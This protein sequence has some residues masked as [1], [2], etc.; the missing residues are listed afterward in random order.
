MKYGYFRNIALLSLFLNSALEAGTNRYWTGASDNLW[1]NNANWDTS[2]PH[3]LD[4]A[5]L[6]NGSASNKNIASDQNIQI[7]SLLISAAGYSLNSAQHDL[8]FSS[9]LN[10]NQNF[11][12]TTDTGSINLGDLQVAQNTL[13]IN[14]TGSG[15]ITFNNATLTGSGIINVTSSSTGNLNV[16]GL[17]TDTSSG[18]LTLTSSGRGNINLSNNAS[19]GATNVILSNNYN[20]LF[21]NQAI[22]NISTG[23]I[24][25]NGSI[26]ING[27]NTTLKGVNTYKGATILNSAVLYLDTAGSISSSKETILNGSSRLDISSATTP[28]TINHLSGDSDAVIN[29]GS[30]NLTVNLNLSYSFAVARYNSDG[31]LD[32]TFGDDGKV[33][34][35]IDN[36]SLGTGVAQQSSGKII[37]GGYSTNN[38]RTD[39]TMVRYNTD[40]SLDSSF[41]EEGIITTPI[42]SNSAYARAVAVD[43]DDHIALAG[44]NYTGSRYN[45][46]VAKYDPNGDLDITF[47][48]SGIVSTEIG[49]SDD[50]ARAVVINN[51]KI[52]AAGYTYLGSGSNYDFALVRYNSDGTLDTNFNGTG[53]VTTSFGVGND[54]A[55]GIA[56]QE[57]DKIVTSGLATI[58]GSQ[59]FALARYNNDGTLD[60][61]FNNTGTVTTSF[62]V[63]S[64]QSNGV[65]IQGDDKIVA[66]G[67]ATIT[68]NNVTTADFALAKY[69]SDGTL[70]TNFNGT[71]KVTTN[72]PFYNND[73]S[74][75]V[76]IQ[77]DEKIVVAGNSSGGEG[78]NF[79]LARYLNDGS[80]DSS[81]GLNGMV[82]TSFG[83]IYNDARSVLIQPDGKIVAA[84]FVN[85]TDCNYY[86]TIEGSGKLIIT[87][88]SQYNRLNLYG[89]NTFS[90]GI[91]LQNSTLGIGNN[92]ALGSGTLTILTS[93]AIVNIQTLGNHTLANPIN[94]VENFYI[95]TQNQEIPYTLTLNGNIEANANNKSLS[96]SG[97]GILI[98]SGN[99]F[100]TPESNTATIYNR[101]YIKQGS[102]NALGTIDNGPSF[103][104]RPASTLDINGFTFPRP[105]NINTI[106]AKIKASGV[107]TSTLAGLVTIEPDSSLILEGDGP[108]SVIQ[109]TQSIPKTTGNSA[110]ITA[111]N[112]T[113]DLNNITVGLNDSDTFV[114]INE[115]AI[116]KGIGIINGDL[117]NYGTNSPGNSIGTITVNGNYITTGNYIC[118]INSAGAS[119]LI[120]VSLNANLGGVLDLQKDDSNP[121]LYGYYIH[122]SYTILTTGGTVS[123]AFTHIDEGA[124]RRFTISTVN[125]SILYNTNNVEIN[126]GNGLLSSAKNEGE[127]K[128]FN[129]LVSLSNPNT[130]QQSLI[131]QILETSSSPIN[132]EQYMDLM[133]LNN[134]ISMH[135]VNAIYNPLRE[136]LASSCYVNHG[137]SRVWGDISAIG[138]NYSK[139][140]YDNGWSSNGFNAALGI[141]SSLSIPLV[142]G[143]TLFFEQNHINFNSVSSATVNSVMGGLYALYR[144]KSY[145]VLGSLNGGYSFQNIERKVL[146]YQNKFNPGSG[147]SNL[148][149]EAGKDFSNVFKPIL[150]QPFAAINLSYNYWGNID[151]SGYLPINANS[152][153]SFEAFTRLGVHLY[154]INSNDI[155]IGMDLNWNYRVSSRINYR[156]ITVAIPESNYSYNANIYGLNLARSSF[157]GAIFASKPIN[158]NW[159]V[160]GEGSTRVW[161]HAIEGSILAGVAYNW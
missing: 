155:L 154:T 118:E 55:Y 64:E 19:L 120:D 138:S 67:W 96:I 16:N 54:Q 10:S 24:S 1:S 105:L 90:G 139:D 141:Q 4:N 72:S 41:G 79:C 97:S 30:K 140:I 121:L 106:D 35:K 53:K 45:L 150:L 153:N 115:N 132:G 142:V 128:L 109:F 102:E 110:S 6:D 32:T 52:T 74:Y 71:G 34:T 161:S 59:D 42:G 86:G 78:Y 25:S 70:D 27:G 152:K 40:G 15:N 126:L 66:V 49:S 156:N 81:F 125:E 117:I 93:S 75:G 113:W 77:N 38:L 123:G 95:F 21:I 157:E 76:A 2:A 98:L 94:F 18:T 116:L 43:S 73:Q 133:L 48:S 22:N 119:D 131:N 91:D 101:G 37:V 9:G 103:L 14:S 88:N 57:D 65:A 151:E 7:Q 46:A 144:P 39:F 137:H 47:N 29:L 134:S 83:Y 63:G 58:S 11:L 3:I 136:I 147:L 5:L 149:I 158:K 51:N 31:T 82:R 107:A 33:V 80:L 148:Y 129:Y 111:R 84:G 87:G 99:N 28:I 44:T 108:L 92:E 100:T 12:L 135:Y 160:Y 61:S 159:K 60:T 36:S 146:D 23:I 20:T 17:V 114:T 85:T 26:E 69:N 112:L 122:D 62:G 145:Y 124:I 8:L 89:T 130:A 104:F 50:G 143:A 13:T 56:I 127:T 68:T